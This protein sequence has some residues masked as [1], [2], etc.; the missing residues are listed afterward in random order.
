MDTEASRGTLRI[1]AASL[2]SGFVGM[3]L[4]WVAAFLLVPGVAA[5]VFYWPGI[6]L[7]PVVAAA[8][9]DK[10]VYWLWPEGGLDATAGLVALSGIALW[11]AFG[12]GI[13]YLWFR[14]RSHN[15]KQK[16]P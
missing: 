2:L 5:A 9:P 6:Q 12:A 4:L 13:A 3:L 8:V 15:E 7:L 16:S 11:W 14:A 1:V 10:M